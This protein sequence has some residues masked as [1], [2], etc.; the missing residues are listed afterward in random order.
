MSSGRR[1]TADSDQCQNGGTNWDPVNN[2]LD[3]RVLSLRIAPTDDQTLYAGIAGGGGVYKTVD[4]GLTWEAV[5]DG[6]P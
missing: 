2:G 3:P 5:N 1:S 6:L 4:G